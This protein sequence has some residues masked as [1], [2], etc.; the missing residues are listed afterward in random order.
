M[1]RAIFFNVSFSASLGIS[2]NLRR[3]FRHA[4]Q[5][6]AFVLL[7]LCLLPFVAQTLPAF[8]EPYLSAAA[9]KHGPAAKERMQN[10]ERL[11]VN[12]R[13]IPEQEKLR[14]A[15]DFWN[16]IPY[17]T[18]LEHWKVNDYWA[19]PAE[20]LATNGGDCEDY[21][22]AKYFTLAAM[23][24]DRNRLK[25]TYVMAD[26][27]AHMVLAYYQT[28]GSVPLILDNLL[29]TIRP[30]DRRPDLRPVYAFNG[31]GMWLI[32]GGTESR[33][34]TPSNIRF[35]RSLLDRMGNEFR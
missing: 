31:D 19:T 25:I 2:Q 17:K 23:G 14:I 18:D 13:N 1:I 15:N 7:A 10:W 5:L 3:T 11:I 33:V 22:I 32:K 9:R 16:R 35:W 8:T 26:V 28:P 4:L 24:V 27:G 6:S 29:P 20:M 30:A 12:N 34:G 21:A